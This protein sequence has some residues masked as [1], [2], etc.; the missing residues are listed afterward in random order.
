MKC[1][2]AM[3]IVTRQGGPK[4]LALTHNDV[5]SQDVLKQEELSCDLQ[6]KL[7]NW[8]I[9]SIQLLTCMLCKFI[10]FSCVVI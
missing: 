3:K 4:F 1:P 6:V 7:A 8:D 10:V 9:G 5:K 2:D